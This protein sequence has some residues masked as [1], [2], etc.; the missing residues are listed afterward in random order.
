MQAAADHGACPI[1][2]QQ[3]DQFKGVIMICRLRFFQVLL[4]L[5]IT[6]LNVGE[7]FSQTRGYS[8]SD[9]PAKLDSVNAI[10][11]DPGRQSKIEA[12]LEELRGSPEDPIILNNLA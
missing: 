4:F 2:W 5:A 3:G 9:A 8:T 7:A 1:K 10:S 11:A 12:L 6:V